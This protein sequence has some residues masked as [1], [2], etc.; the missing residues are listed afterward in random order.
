MDAVNYPKSLPCLNGSGHLS[1][2]ICH[3]SLVICHLS[4]VI[5][6][7]SLVIGHLSLVIGHWSL[8]IGHWSLVIG[9]GYSPCPHAPF[10][11]PHSPCPFSKINLLQ[12]PK[13]SKRFC[14]GIRLH[15][16]KMHTV[17]FLLGFFKTFSFC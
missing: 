5:C 15:T 7:W 13:T 4:F 6:H 16:D 11:M 12:Q 3:W 10:P 14:F 2:V 8:V 9:H 17:S 1:F